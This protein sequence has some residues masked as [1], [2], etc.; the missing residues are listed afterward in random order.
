MNKYQVIDLFQAVE[1]FLMDFNQTIMKLSWE[2][3]IGDKALE[4]FKY[5]HKNSLV[6]NGFT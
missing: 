3:I 1:V 2:L 6:L 5:N 4:T